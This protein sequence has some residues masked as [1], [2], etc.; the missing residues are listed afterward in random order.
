MRS[1]RENDPSL[2]ANHGLEPKK[3]ALTRNTNHPLVCAPTNVTVKHG[4]FSGTMILKTSKV[5]GGITYE[6]AA[7][8]GDPTLEESWTN[9]GQFAHCSQMEVKGL[10]PGKMYHFRVRCFGVS[11]HGPWSSIVSLM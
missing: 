8:Q 5:T 7:C 11:G 3:R 4:P 10:E 2:I 6:I 1:L 9:L